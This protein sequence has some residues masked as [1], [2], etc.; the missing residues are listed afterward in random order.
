MDSYEKFQKTQVSSRLLNPWR[1]C[2]KE[3]EPQGDALARGQRY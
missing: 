1:T 3:E 2:G